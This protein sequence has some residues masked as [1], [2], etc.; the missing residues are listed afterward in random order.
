MSFCNLGPLLTFAEESAF[1]NVTSHCIYQPQQVT[2][3]KSSHRHLD[4]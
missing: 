2:A 3:I 1:G 4:P